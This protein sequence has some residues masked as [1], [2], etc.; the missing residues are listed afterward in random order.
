M[1]IKVQYSLGIP[2]GEPR[3]L[4]NEMSF[5]SPSHGWA[6]GSERILKTIDGGQTWK[7]VFPSPGFFAYAQSNSLCTPSDQICWMGSTFFCECC[8]TRDSG[9]TWERL[10]LGRGMR[11]E[12]MCFPTATIGWMITKDPQIP[13]GPTVLWTTNSG[14]TAWEQREIILAGHPRILRCRD[15]RNAWLLENLS[16]RNGNAS[17]RILRTDDRGVTWN[18]VAEIDDL[19]SDFDI[20]QTGN[21]I[22][23]GIGGVYR[24]DGRDGIVHPILK[25]AMGMNGIK[26]LS[27]GQVLAMGDEGCLALSKDRGQT[28]DVFQ[29]VIDSNLIAAHEVSKT[30]FLLLAEESIIEVRLSR[31]PNERKASLA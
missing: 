11:V 28:W 27:N 4:L 7:N 24:I 15:G 19:V 29:A 13:K 14:G 18:K 30:R 25:S 3:G 20:E 2:R 31:S 8:F 17:S 1:R 26:L 10:S 23:S 22:A 6:I 9:R 21:L 12:C 5:S 16:R